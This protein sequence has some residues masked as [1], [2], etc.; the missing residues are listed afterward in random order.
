MRTGEF[1][2]T[3]R[4]NTDFDLSG[5][6][7]LTLNVTHPDSSTGSHTMTLGTTDLVVDSLGT[8]KANE[9][10]EYIVQ[11]ND[12]TQVGSHTVSV[13][14]DF[15]SSQRLKSADGTFSMEA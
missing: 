12:F 2:F 4:V 11:E 15:G 5:N 14:A 9:Y 10:V 3:I 13:T 1:G 7:L 6:T 8:F